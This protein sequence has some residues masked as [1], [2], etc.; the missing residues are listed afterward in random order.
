[1]DGSTFITG[2]IGN[3]KKMNWGLW[4]EAGVQGSAGEQP[5]GLLSALM[6]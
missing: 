1:M 5:T 4:C 6:T 2:F 3:P